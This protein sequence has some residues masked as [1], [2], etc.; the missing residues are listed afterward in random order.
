M[1][2]L[3]TIALVSLFAYSG[4]GREIEPSYPTPLVIDVVGR[5][6]L[7]S[8]TY[9]GA[10]KILGTEDDLVVEKDLHLPLGHDIHLRLTSEDYIYTFRARELGLRELAVPE[11]QFDLDFRTESVGKYELEVDPLCAIRFLHGDEMGWLVI[12]DGEVFE[13]WLLDAENLKKSGAGI[14]E[15]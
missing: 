10:D 2:W 7:W 11:L 1:R 8:F 9:P 12:E 6:F 5:D 15:P 4:C 13:R 14:R 3:P